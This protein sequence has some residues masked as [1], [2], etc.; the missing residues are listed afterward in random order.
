MKVTVAEMTG[1]SGEYLV[2]IVQPAKIEGAE[3]LQ[4]VK[5]DWEQ[6]AA[7]MGSLAPTEENKQTIKTMRA[8]ERKRRDEIWGRVKA[9]IDAVNEPAKALRVA[10]DTCVEE[11]FKRL[12]A[13]AKS[14]IDSIEAGQKAGALLQCKDYYGELCG[15]H[16][17]DFVPWEM[18]VRL[19]GFKVS[20]TE[21]QKKAPTGHFNTINE[22]LS[23]VACDAEAIEDPEVMA[24]Y[25]ANGLSLAKAQKA[26][27]DRREA[28]ELERKAAEERAEAKRREAEAVARV[29]A[30]APPEVLAPPVVV[31]PPAVGET[32]APVG[33]KLLTVAFKATATREKLIRL[34][35]WMK[36]EGIKY[37]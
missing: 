12:D 3:L 17:V 1:S 2:R 32:S 29:E 9:A 23:R 16:G 10:F 19:A 35:E 18:F 5:A 21:A 20:M 28:A 22:F 26:V 4:A 13:A 36:A 25:K 30:A 7:T 31:S 34:R 27:R 11:P 33:E 15:V 24:E 8:E 14:K 6:R 37:E